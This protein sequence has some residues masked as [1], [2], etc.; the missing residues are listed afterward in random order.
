[1]S[2]LGVLEEIARLAADPAMSA[3]L[4][5]APTTT[6]VPRLGSV[7]DTLPD[8]N[9]RAVAEYYA[10]NTGIEPG[11]QMTDWAKI[12]H[13]N[14]RE[15]A[16]AY[17]QMADDPSDPLVSASYKQLG[18][19]TV[20]QLQALHDAGY[21]FD[22]MPSGY[23]PYAAS[24]RLA[25]EDLR[26]NKHLYVFPTEE[27]YGTLS[28]AQQANPLLRPVRGMS[29]IFNGSPFV[30]NDAFRAVHDS[31]GHGPIA[32]G[33]R[34]E[35]EENAFRNHAGL[36]SDLARI[37][38]GN[39]TRGQN[40]FVNFSDRFVPEKGMTV[41]QWNKGKSGADTIYADQ[42]AGVMPDFVYNRGLHIPPIS[43]EELRRIIQQNPQLGVLLALSLL[44]A[45][46]DVDVESALAA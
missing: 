35:G 2:R 43:T 1:M 41:A 45:G 26:N 14:A 42:K 6:K 38:L 29:H 12:D 4:R 28:E 7:L 13:G 23:D 39:E 36:Y 44:S 40:S 27:G 18:R 3:P 24:P 33:F 19:E 9:L 46:G 5:G 17:D 37:G 8:P 32:A 10:R 25:L 21:R 31:L 34:A 22:F 16:R 30:E 15:Y 11:R 20:D